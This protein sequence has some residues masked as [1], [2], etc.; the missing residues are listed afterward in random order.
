MLDN[1][2]SACLL[3][4][5]QKAAGDLLRGALELVLELGVLAGELERERLE[6]YQAAPLL[7]D[8]YATFRIKMSTLVCTF[9]H[10]YCSGHS[11]MLDKTK[12]LKALVDK[13][14][15]I[16]RLQLEAAMQEAGEGNSRKPPGGAESLYHLLIR[17]DL[18]EW[19]AGSTEGQRR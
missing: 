13:G 12:V 14:S 16:S 19:W 6:E 15:T 2:L 3:R 10:T 18:G 4:S 11:L 1:M 5:G 7:E 8:L 17:L 9:M